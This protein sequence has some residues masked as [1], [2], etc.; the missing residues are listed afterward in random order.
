MIGLKVKAGAL[1]LVLFI[2]I[3]IAL[4][5]FGFLAFIHMQTKFD[6]QNDLVSET[7]R[8]AQKGIDF[9]LLNP[10]ALQDTT[11]LYINSEYKTIKLTKSY[12]GLFEKITAI[13]KIKNYHFQKIALLGAASNIEEKV[14]LQVE[15]YNKPL[16]LVGQTRIQGNAILPAQG[17]KPGYI[18]GVSYYGQQLIEGNIKVGTKLP[19]FTREQKQQW[20]SVF[21][22]P[23]NNEN[24]VFVD[25]ETQRTHQN[26][27]K[28]KEHIIYSNGKISLIDVVLI[29]HIKV[30]SNTQITVSASTKL[31]DVL[32]VAP[33]IIIEKGVRGNFQAFAN[34]EIKVEENVKLSYPSVLA[35]IDSNNNLE[36]PIKSKIEIGKQADIQGSVLFFAKNPKYNN[37][38]QV[39]LEESSLVTGE[40]YCNQNLELKGSVFGTIYTANFI[41]KQSGSIYQ[42]HIYNGTILFNRLPSKY[43]GLSFN[44]EKPKKIIKW[45]Y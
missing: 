22:L 12:W 45:L 29:G 20:E 28:E 24:I 34:Q 38:V 19:N 7:V 26:S 5:L 1:Q 30:Q 4:L 17:V 16:V 2:S 44:K 18:A 10:I 42:N 32:L 13:S 31:K 43:V 8:N 15:D 6:K 27:F 21:E 39:L 25:L 9:A 35:L 37:D 3:I 40:V 36:A 23:M 33:K 41:A 14:A 11:S